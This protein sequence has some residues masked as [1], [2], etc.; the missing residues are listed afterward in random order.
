M[1]KQGKKGSFTIYWKDTIISSVPKHRDNDY[2]LYMNDSYKLLLN[3]MKKGY[4]LKEII[5]I[6]FAQIE[7]YYLKKFNYKKKLRGQDHEMLASSVLVLLRLGKLEK[8][9]VILEMGRKKPRQLVRNL[10]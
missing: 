10:S 2:E 9:D 7:M 8:D 6:C 4:S 3:Q 5:K 1:I